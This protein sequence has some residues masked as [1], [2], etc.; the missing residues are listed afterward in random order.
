MNL[1]SK[2]R[3]LGSLFACAAAIGFCMPTQAQTLKMGTEAWLGY[4]QWTVAREKE[5]FKKHGLTDVKT[6]NFAED[7]DLNAA[8]MSGQIDVANVATHTALAMIAAGAPIKIVMVL[9]TSLTADAMISNDPKIARIE[10][11]KGKSV[12]YEEGATSHILLSYALSTKGMSIKDVKSVPMPAAQAGSALIAKQVPVAVTYEP[13]LA[14]ARSADAKTHM[15]V[16]GN[17]LPGLISDVLVARTEI[18]NSRPK[19]LAGLVSSWDEAL[20]YYKANIDTSRQ[21]MAKDVGAT[22]SELKDA[23][24]GVR[25]YSLADNK[26]ELSKSF[27]SNTLPMVQKAGMEAGLIPKAIE[28]QSVIDSQFVNAAK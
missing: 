22:L 14:A 20:S 19:Q 9:D 21:L 25:Y 2:S 13:Y 27:Q 26:N 8:L 18:I 7:K 15:I 16:A 4:G 10:D 28:L 24:D 1:A 5:I 23:F 11:L 6:V 17:A 3:I 12:A